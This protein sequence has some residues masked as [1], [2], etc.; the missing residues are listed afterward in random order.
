MKKILHILVVLTLCIGID[1]ISAYTEYK[2]GDVVPYNGMDFYVIKD[3]SSS[4][5][6]VTMLKAEPLTYEEV[7]QYSEG[8][9]AHISNQ[10]GYGGMQYHLNSNNYATS[11]IKSVVDKWALDKVKNYKKVRLLTHDELVT[12]LG[13]INTNDTTKTIPSSNGDTPLWVYNND[14]WYWTQSNYNDSTNSLWVVRNNGTLHDNGY[15][16]G[17]LD[18]ECVVRPVVIFSKIT[19]GDE[20]ESTLGDDS[21][22]QIMPEID[23]EIN[24]NNKTN[25]S[26]TTVK[27][28]NTYMSKSITIIILG[29]I[30]A[31]I[32]VFIIY[33][34]SNKKK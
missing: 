5:D 31:S 27:V 11:Y 8:I 33:K 13:Y 17:V 6:S 34:L 26:K 15:K 4:E 14:Y 19:L 16:G 22:K 7:Q 21:D 3:S 18:T 9:G 10:K 28:A 2:I 12:D 1:R 32:S 24:N 23:K 20:D 25:E 29:F 30:I